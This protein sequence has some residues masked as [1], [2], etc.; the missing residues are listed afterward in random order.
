MGWY[1]WA[2]DG[3]GTQ[4]IEFLL[5]LLVI[6]GVGYKCITRKRG[7]QEQTARDGAKQKQVIEIEARDDIKEGEKR[8]VIFRQTQ[9]AGSNAEQCQIGKIKR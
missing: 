7:V 4:I 3:V 5:G 8:D 9:R 2:F 1:E 6:G